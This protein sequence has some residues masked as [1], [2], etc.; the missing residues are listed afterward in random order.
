MLKSNT[1]LFKM[2][3]IL[4]PPCFLQ[5]PEGRKDMLSG[6]PNWPELA[7][8][9]I[10]NLN[11]YTHKHKHTHIPCFY[12]KQRMQKLAPS[13]GLFQSEIHNTTQE[14]KRT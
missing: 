8:C 2:P 14:G 4:V 13:A 5:P 1:K 9:T 7:L 3:G 12:P 10:N 6:D 11:I